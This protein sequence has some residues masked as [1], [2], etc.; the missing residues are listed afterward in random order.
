[1]KEIMPVINDLVLVFFNLLI[2]MQT[3]P[4]RKDDRLHRGIVWT[5]CIGLLGLYFQAAYVFLVPISLA[6]LYCVSIPSMLLFLC[7]GRYQDSRVLLTLG[8]VNTVMLVIGFVLN[9]IGAL[10]DGSLGPVVL[11]LTLLASVAAYCLLRPWCRRFRELLTV[12]DGGW[13]GMAVVSAIIYVV[14]V[15]TAV[16]PKPLAERMEYGPSY[17]A[18]CLVVVSFYYVFFQS[19]RKTKVIY[20]KNQDLLR[21]K[22]YHHI[23]YTDALTG[24]KNRAA[25]MERLAALDR[26]EARGLPAGLVLFDMNEFKEINDTYGHRSGDMVLRFF[27]R[28]A[29]EAFCGEGYAVYRIGGDEFVVL[30]QPADREDLLRRAAMVQRR[31]ETGGPLPVPISAAV[32]V[33]IRP[34]GSAERPENLFVRAD[35]AMYRRKAAD[36]QEDLLG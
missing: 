24:L 31:L 2:F 20:Q 4:L 13:L 30:A 12:E 33:A 27:G 22:K 1:M 19:M 3:I 21:E 35:Q 34:A 25:Y 26:A 15:F 29:Q 6:A 14:L 36:K 10:L 16:Y 8:V 5:A 11:V 7:L 9:W 17:L 23:A 18:L 32:G 28:A